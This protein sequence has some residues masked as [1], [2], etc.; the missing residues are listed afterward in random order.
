MADNTPEILTAENDT[1]NL[2]DDFKGLE[3]EE[4]KAQ[5]DQNRS[6]FH[7]AIENFQHDFNIGAIARNANAFNAAGIHIIGRRHWNRRGAMKTEAYMHVFHHQTVADFVAWARENQ[8]KLIAI[9][10]QKGAEN[11]SEAILEENSVLIFG[12]E[13]DGLSAEMLE[14][15]EKMVAIEQFGSTRSVNVGVASGI[16]MY[17]FVRR[18]RLTK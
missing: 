5:L 9:D 16:L 14:N 12:N 8:L 11:L 3:V 10:N 18:N 13:S 17:E 2:I 15:C 7:V 6:H 4:I 1:R